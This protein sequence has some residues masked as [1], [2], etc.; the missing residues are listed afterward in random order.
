MND[1]KPEPQPSRPHRRP[2]GRATPRRSAFALAIVIAVGVAS[3]YISFLTQQGLDTSAA[4][5]VGLPLLLAYVFIMTGKAKS[6]TGSILKGITIALLLSAPVLRE[7]FICILMAA[8]IFY[9]IGAVI[10]A[11]TDWARRRN[12]GRLQSAPVVVLLI[13][14]SLEGTHESLSF[15]RDHS[16]RVEKLLAATPEAI[17]AQLALPSGRSIAPRK[18]P[19]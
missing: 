4:L 6:A 12:S 14:L 15:D 17:A 16:V 9:I 10:G 18:R 1:K 11:A 19:R 7:G 2:P 5:Y 13:L 8:P 3:L